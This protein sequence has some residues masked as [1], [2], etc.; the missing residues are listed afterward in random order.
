MKT[1]WQNILISGINDVPGL[2]WISLDP[3]K[4]KRVKVTANTSVLNV[5]MEFKKLV[6]T[7]LIQSKIEKVSVTNGEIFTMDMKIP[8]VNIKG[9]YIMKGNVLVLNLDGKGPFNIDLGDI[10]LRFVVKSKRVSR[11]SEEFFEVQS[12]KTNV[13]HLGS[14]H[15][16][17]NNLFGDN[18]T[19]TDSAN[20]VFNQNWHDLLGL[21]RPVIEEAMDASLLDQGKKYLNKLPGRIIF[22][23]L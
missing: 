3:Y 2:K 10:E 11:D 1:L 13:K 4:V 20:D 16:K 8:K 18:E 14:L 5:T 17:F 19:L 15:V 21:M 7:G 23:D 12:V 9:N 6:L 22:S